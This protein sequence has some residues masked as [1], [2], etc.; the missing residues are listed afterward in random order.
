MQLS[1]DR[2][3]NGQAYEVALEWSKRRLPPVVAVNLPV[4]AAAAPA[5]PGEKRCRGGIGQATMIAP[6]PGVILDIAVKPGDKVAYGEL[7]CALE[8]MKMKNAIRAPRDVV[9]ASVEVQEGQKSHLRRCA[10]QVLA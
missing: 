3:V 10:V 8:A 9:I 1:D 2:V 4:A 5:R 6:M 7:L